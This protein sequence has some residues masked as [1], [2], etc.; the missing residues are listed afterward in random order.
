MTRHR[1]DTPAQPPLLTLGGGLPLGPRKRAHEVAERIEQTIAAGNYAAGDRLPSEKELAQSLGVG[2]PAVR[3]ALF[4]LQQA[5]VVEISNGTRARVTTPDDRFLVAQLSAVTR[6]LSAT[7]EGQRHVEQGRWVL[8]SGVAAMAAELATDEDIRRLKAALDRNATALGNIP[9][10]VRT[11]VAYHYEIAL[12]P[13]NPIFVA[14]HE[15]VVEW[16]T[17]QRTRTINLPDADRFSVRDHT[18]IFEAIAAHDPMRA[19]HE[20]ASHLKL[21]SQLYQE[22]RRISEQILGDMTRSVA[23]RIEREQA[24]LWAASFG[25]RAAVVAPPDPRPRRSRKAPQ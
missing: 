7:P 20:M 8:E 2:R 15:V 10:F 14:I 5:G 6:R 17:E 25:A 11:D 12:I 1:P 4:L 9:E 19:F 23:T 22:A 3:E 24:E 21:V 13:R 16:L 18:A